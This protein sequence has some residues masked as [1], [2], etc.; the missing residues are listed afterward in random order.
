MGGFGDNANGYP[1]GQPSEI[2][3]SI[4]NVRKNS[5]KF[6]YSFLMIISLMENLLRIFLTSI[7]L[8]AFG[9]E[10]Y[11]SIRKKSVDYSLWAIIVLLC[12]DIWL[13]QMFLITSAIY[14]I[15]TLVVTLLVI[16]SY[17]ST[18]KVRISHYIR[19]TTLSILTLSAIWYIFLNITANDI[20]SIVI[21]T[22]LN[23][24]STNSI[25]QVYFKYNDRS[26]NRTFNMNGYEG[27]ENLKEDYVVVLHIKP[28]SKDIVKL[29]AIELKLK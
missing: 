6:A 20:N 13:S 2:S 1:R 4:D 9:K 11:W 21:T 3:A 18:E 25:D 7:I 22:P 12:I 29:E 23:G 8:Y 10:I 14:N 24:F 16:V 19:A 28:I 26:F 27:I 15:L 5:A 17:A